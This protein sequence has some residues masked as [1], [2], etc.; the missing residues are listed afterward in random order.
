MEIPERVY[1][2]VVEKAD[3][4]ESGCLVSRYSVGSHGYAQVGWYTQGRQSMTLCHRAIWQYV[5]GKL[6][7]GMTVDHVCHNRRCVN[8]NHLR[9][10]SNFE[11]ARRNKAGKDWPLGECAQGHPNTELIRRAGRWRCRICLQIKSRKDYAK[12]RARTD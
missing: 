8:I 4:N 10:L 9:L 2:R 7:D 3:V 5:N 11:N 6:P 1:T 12:R